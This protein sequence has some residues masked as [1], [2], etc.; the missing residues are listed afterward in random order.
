[1]KISLTEIIKTG[2]IS[3]FKWGDSENDFLRVFLEWETKI[4]ESKNVLCPF[5]EIDFVEFYFK[6]EFYKKLDSI[7]I[8]VW[9]FDK[10]YKSDYFDHDWIRD[11]LSLPQLKSILN[12]E[13]WFYEELTTPRSEEPYILTNRRTQLAFDSTGYNGYEEDKTELQKIFIYPEPIT[14]E[15]V[16]REGN[17]ITFYNNDSYEKP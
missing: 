8:G 6:D 5:I 4:T 9:H 11:D 1:M 3:P 16:N 2:D 12:K 7:I 13:K 10:N 17:E 14:D 15:F